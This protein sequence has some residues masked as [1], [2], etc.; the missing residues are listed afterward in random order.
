MPVGLIVP[1]RLSGTAGRSEVPIVPP[2]EERRTF[3]P[4]PAPEFSATQLNATAEALAHERTEM[5]RYVAAE[6]K[7]LRDEVVQLRAELAVRKEIV[8]FHEQ[9]AIIRNRDRDQVLD[10]TALPERKGAA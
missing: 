2:I 5:R 7:S 1:V 4:P 10:L 6:I 9:L 3:V 8:G